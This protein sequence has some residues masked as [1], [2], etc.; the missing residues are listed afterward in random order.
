MIL[1]DRSSPE[2]VQRSQQSHTHT[3]RK[4]ITE[5]LITVSALTRVLRRNTVLCCF[6][7]FH[8]SHYCFLHTL[9][10][11]LVCNKFR[12][13]LWGGG[14]GLLKG[15]LGNVGT[16]C[17]ALNINCPIEEHFAGCRSDGRRPW[18]LWNDQK[19]TKK[20]HQFGSFHR[21]RGAEV[22]GDGV[23][24]GCVGRTSSEGSAGQGG[25]HDCIKVATTWTLCSFANNCIPLFFKFYAA[26]QLFWKSTLCIKYYF[27]Y[28]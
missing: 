3:Q 14:G 2:T 24:T 4:S 9:N 6:S 21:W 17:N 7:L 1:K 15:I 19:K 11:T 13:V 16:T 25:V 22:T 20:K 5:D 23:M 18:K 12:H 10:H 8:H 28:T 26:F 27:V